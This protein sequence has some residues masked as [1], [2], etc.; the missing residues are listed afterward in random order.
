VN[1]IEILASLTGLHLP[2][3]LALLLTLAFVIFLFRWDIRE[4]RDVSGALWL[5]LLWVVLIASRS[6]VQWLNTLGFMK[7]GSGEEGNP[8]DAL[9]YFAL[10]LAG[11]GVLNQ[12]QVSLSEVLRNNAWLMA[13]LAYCFLAIVWSDFPFVSFKRWIKILGHPIMV[14]IVFTEVDPEEALLRL[15]KRSAYILVPFSILAIKYYPEIGRRFDEWSGLPINC[16]I[17][18]SKNQL[19][20]VCM[21]LGLFFFWWLLQIWRAPKS[22]DRRNELYLIGG[23]LVMIGWLFWKAHS[24]TSALSLLIAVTVILLLG[25]R[26]VNKKLI[27]TYVILA[28]VVLVVA[29][30]TFGI[31]E[32]VVDLTGHEATLIGRREL[33]REL[34]ALHTN[35]IFGVGFESFWLGDR[36]VLLHEGRPW[37]PN[38]A[39]NGYLEIYLDLG[40]L[41]LL[42]LVA[43][44]IATFRKVRLE[45]SRNFE[46][47]RFRLAFLIALVFYNW[48]EASFRGLSLLWFAFY[49]IALDY[50]NVRYEPVVGS[51][52]A[53]VPEEEGE[54]AYY[55]DSIQSII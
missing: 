47:G 9:I 7:V 36:L 51:L 23:L 12:R 6:P 48:T 2:P 30:L 53:V 40:L 10:I 45:L 16:G 41:G 49:I 50:R 21:L 46:W 39:H 15:M 35:P 34:F 42:M 3:T 24:A 20:A 18:Q 17:T 54:F 27:G 8:L 26:W 55:S 4:K 14:L 32:R 37:Q 33:W 11:I 52:E 44:I 25:R 1:R 38:E 29:E 19:G 13:F 28:V 31:F 22:K 43:V 5:S